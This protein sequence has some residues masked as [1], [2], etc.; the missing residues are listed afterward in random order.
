M[1][2]FISTDFRETSHSWT[3]VKEGKFLTR[4][5]LKFFYYKDNSKIFLWFLNKLKRNFVFR[6]KL[7]ILRLLRAWRFLLQTDHQKLTFLGI[8]NKGLYVSLDFHA[9]TLFYWQFLLIQSMLLK[10]WR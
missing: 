8:K 3:K 5:F 7:K 6:S 10:K 4:S 1:F 9:H 2:Q